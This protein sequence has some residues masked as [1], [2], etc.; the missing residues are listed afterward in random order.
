MAKKAG[1]SA[2]IEVAR[3][4][5]K[6]S[7]DT[8]GFRGE[9]K[10]D[11]EAIEKS[12]NGIKADVEIKGHFNG[13]QAL[14]DF[15]RLLTVMRAEGARGVKIT[16]HLDVDRN[17]PVDEVKRLGQR[18]KSSW[19]S[20]LPNFGSGINPAGYAVILAGI[21]AAIA[22]LIGLVTTALVSLPGLITAV[23]VP[24]AALSLG[25]DGLKAAA[26]TLKQ[27]FEDLKRTMSDAVQEQFTP[28]FEKLGGIF[29]TLNAALPTVSQGLADMATAFANSVTS[30]EGMKTIDGIIRNIGASLSASAPG[31]QSFTDGLLGLVKA[32]TDE[33]PG[34]SDWFNNTGNS[35]KAWV[36]EMTAKSWF[37]GKSPLQEAFDG[38]GET[39]RN[40]LNWLGDLGQK[41]LDFMSDPEKIKNFNED[42]KLI[43]ATLS[44]IVDLSNKFAEARKGWSLEGFKEKANE[45]GN[46]MSDGLNTND[47]LPDSWAPKWDAF[48]NNWG[49]Q[50]KLIW[51]DTKTFALDTW[52]QIKLGVSE[53]WNALKAQFQDG[54]AFN[55]MWESVKTNASNAWESIKSNTSSAWEDVKTTVSNGINDV[56]KWVGELPEK[57]TNALG[58]LRDLLVDAGKAAMKGLLQGI[59][60]GAQKVYDF[61]SGIAKKIADLKGPLPYDRQVLVPN[62]EALMS[63]LGKGME[64]GFQPVL[65][66][67]KGM[68]Q[69]IADAFASGADP[70]QVLAGWDK[71]EIARTE[72][73]LGFDIKNMEREIR[74][75]N[76]Q[77][78]LTDD[79][80]L[81]DSIKARVEE[82]R[83]ILDS[84]KAQKDMLDLTEEYA[85]VSSSASGGDPFVKAASGLMKA[86]VDFAKSTGKQFMSDL[87]ISG[88]G[89]I[90]KA[91]TE[92]ISYVFQIGSV[93]E[94][95]SI[96]D[97]ETS[98]NTMAITGGAR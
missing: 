45:R 78:S 72:K 8:K 39:I 33:L 29:P 94:A 71:K 16:A 15:R 23:A 30:S 34:L 13:A 18:M 64:N 25:M 22:P 56:V 24:I 75:M 59:R 57:I 28:M 11:L 69:Q 74:A 6:V 14:A 83:A 41:G 93:D 3:I 88:D 47:F 21:V 92:G 91:I 4:S 68:A 2:G 86:P 66:Q 89:F 65:D 85:D 62:G 26:S 48:W 7:P 90:S 17:D 60:D 55:N 38:L 51:S 43:A 98:K 19:S 82:K 96:K 27:P 81:K 63:G 77:A 76:A 54:G 70:T 9:L 46:K 58:D 61:V 35:F 20:M 31:V 79:K 97:R 73:T 10:R 49:E 95:L 36:E 32:F 40:I 80:G 87:G 1:M 67:A 12:A 44:S 37:T 84:L 5:V 42:L 52:D 53:K 50:A